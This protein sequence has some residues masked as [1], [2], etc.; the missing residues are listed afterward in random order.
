[1]PANGLVSRSITIQLG[2]LIN[3]PLDQKRSMKAKSRS[4]IRLGIY[5]RFYA[6]ISKVGN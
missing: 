1:M 2:G 4:Q 5:F 6:D 3:V